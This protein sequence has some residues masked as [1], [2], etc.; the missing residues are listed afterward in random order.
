MAMSRASKAFLVLLVSLYLLLVGY[1]NVV[2]YESNFGFVQHVLLMD[3]IF[4]GNPLA[5]RSVSSPVLH[6]GVYWVII[7]GEFTAGALCFLG[8]LKLFYHVRSDR[9]S[10]SRAKT[11]AVAGLTLG[12]AL[13]FFGFMTIAGEW[14]LMWQSQ[15]WNGQQAAFRLIVCMGIVLI[16]LM[17]SDI[18]ESVG[19]IK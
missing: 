6:H 10:F 15:K 9:V 7:L 12:I 18:D 1:N 13:W 16:Y 3:S 2:D 8:A 11:L 5:S 17:Q 19:S 4:P 14:F